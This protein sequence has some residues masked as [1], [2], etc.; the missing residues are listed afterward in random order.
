MFYLVGAPYCK[1]YY[2]PLSPDLA[3]FAVKKINRKGNTKLFAR[4]NDLQIGQAK[5]TKKSN[6]YIP[7]FAG[8][9]PEIP[10]I[11]FVDY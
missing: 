10:Q 9:P 1:T 11:P 2:I 3:P 8:T 4:L 6:G 5:T 7:C